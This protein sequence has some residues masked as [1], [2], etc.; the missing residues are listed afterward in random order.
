M[1]KTPTL[2]FVCEHGAAK[3]VVAAAYFNKLASERDL[4][5]RAIARGT[6]P[7]AE[8]SPKTVEGLKNDGLTPTESAPQKLSLADMESAQRVVAFCNL[9]EE[10][11]SKAP[12]E[13][14][15]DVP[16]V[17]EDYEKARD[18][19]LEKVNQLVNSW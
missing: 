5:I 9:P 18:A 11:Q 13:Q 19:I 10:Y 14:W 7:D 16:P 17:S 8:L 1:T 2:I 3:S 15:N 12:T 6:T 4:K